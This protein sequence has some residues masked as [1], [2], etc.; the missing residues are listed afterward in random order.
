MSFCNVFYFVLVC[1]V[2]IFVPLKYFSSVWFDRHHDLDYNEE[3]YV[4]VYQEDVDEIFEDLCTRTRRE[5]IVRL[6]DLLS[7]F[8]TALHLYHKTFYNWL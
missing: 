7:L 4:H 2:F 1:F 6:I 5:S 8:N 3:I